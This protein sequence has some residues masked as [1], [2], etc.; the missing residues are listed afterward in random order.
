MVKLMGNFKK[1]FPVMA[2]MF[3]I[4]ILCS[5]PLWA[6]DTDTNNT[7]GESQVMDIYE[8]DN[9]NEVVSSNGTYASLNDLIINNDLVELDKSYVYNSSSDSKLKDGI[10]IDKNVVIEGNG[11][12]INSTDHA[13]LFTITNKGSLTLKNI[14]LLNDYSVSK[15]GIINYGN[16]IFD[17]V[18]FTSQKQ[19]VGGTFEGAILNEGNFSICNSNFKDSM[20]TYDGAG[21]AFISGVLIKSSGNLIIENTN[22]LN[23][24]IQISG[25]SVQIKGAMIYNSGRL[26]LN[27]I[28]MSDN[29]GKFKSRALTFF[30]FVLTSSSSI[31]V[32][33]SS[34]S[35][36]AIINDGVK[37]FVATTNVLRIISSNASVSNSKFFNNTGSINAGAI[38]YY[39]NEE[40][41]IIENCLFDSNAVVLQGGAVF[42]EGNIKSNNNTY[43]NNFAGR[44]GGAIYVYG[45]YDAGNPSM[46]NFITTNDVFEY[47]SVKSFPDDDGQARTL[48]WGGAICSK[49][50]NLTVINDTFYRNIAIWGDGGAIANYLS[51]HLLVSHC[52]FKENEATIW[53]SWTHASGLGGAIL[54]PETE[55]FD[56]ENPAEFIV[57]YSIFDNNIATAGTGLY[58]VPYKNV[59]CDFISNYNYWGSNNPFFKELIGKYQSSKLVFPDNYIIMEMEGE[60]TVHVG[61][62]KIYKFALKKINENGVIK[63]LNG[64]LP[65]F[66][67]TV[68]S[69]LNPLLNNTILFKNGEANFTYN[70]LKDGVETFFINGKSFKTQVQVVKYDLDVNVA[71][72]DD[73]ETIRITLSDNIN[74]SISLKVNNVE[75]FAS[76]ENG[77]ASVK[78]PGLVPGSHVIT[79]SYEGDDKYN[80][81]SIDG[82]VTVEKRVAD[83]IVTDGNIKYPST[84]KINLYFPSD[85]TGRVLFNIGGKS[86]YADIVNGVASLDISSIGAG[87]YNINWIYLGDERYFKGE[88][89]F[90]VNILVDEKIINNKNIQMFYTDNSKYAVRI[91]GTDGKPVG[92]GKVVKFTIN[93]KTYSAK[94]DKKGY[95]SLTIKLL[96]KTYTIIAKYNKAQ[97]KNTIVVK[98]VLS[99]KSV[100]VKKAKKI[101]YSA[102]VKGKKAF[103]NKKVTF[104]V[105]GKTY[106]AKTNKKGVAIVYLK[107]LKVGK[108]KVI[109]QY[110]GTKLTKTIS[111]KR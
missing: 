107:N 103:A 66:E 31:L 47:N 85:A 15:S 29:F 68:S 19:I 59:P 3:I 54:L 69:S 35:N 2:L 70:A 71:Y 101:K 11:F 17:N 30:G 56:E 8:T 63:D 27:N 53:G 88:G 105:K 79:I 5:S 91:L 80:A 98:K 57:E 42:A 28:N 45:Y 81:F 92:Y 40:Q 97:V 100:S 94:T 74:G 62:S 24:G 21:S 99:A 9:L 109:V 48:S 49:A 50:G 86:T 38:G 67:F 110:E 65:D 20:L 73:I 93:G 18:T 102:T 23:N 37:S 34:F 39:N 52:I 36:N 14:I 87:K 12:T 32:D 90:S 4:L 78:V 44:N 26:V 16:L 60:K 43:R 83:V 61:D 75:Y 106:T 6:N 111:V 33:N 84:S 55:M 96:P 104:K 82:N 41:M 10:K 46:G 22:F 64:T 72:I 76:I 7:L 25:S 89:N 95:A 108:N 51:S 13:K 58:S 77:S 1:N